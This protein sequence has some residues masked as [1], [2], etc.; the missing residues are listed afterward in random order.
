MTSHTC[1]ASLAKQD[2]HWGESQVSTIHSYIFLILTWGKHLSQVNSP[3]QGRLP[4][5]IRGE[6]QANEEICHK[7]F[8]VRFSDAV[9]R[10]QQDQPSFGFNSCRDF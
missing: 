6:I 7:N 8:C 2:E 1:S 10:S 5:R 4:S 3:S 9:N